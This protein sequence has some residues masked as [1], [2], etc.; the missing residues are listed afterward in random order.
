MKVNSGTV[1]IEKRNAKYS[2]LI[3]I[4]KKKKA[5]ELEKFV[6]R[7]AKTSGVRSNIKSAKIEKTSNGAFI[8]YAAIKGEWGAEYED[9][10]DVLTG[11]V[12][13]FFELKDREGL[14]GPV[15]FEEHGEPLSRYVFF[16]EN[17]LKFVS[18]DS[19]LYDTE[20]FNISGSDVEK[21]MIDYFKD[22]N[23]TYLKGGSGY[24]FLAEMV[25]VEDMKETL[26]SRIEVDDIQYSRETSTLT[27]RC[28]DYEDEEIS[29]I[30][31]D[32]AFDIQKKSTEGSESIYSMDI[33]DYF[34][35][36]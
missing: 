26:I 17:N 33:L 5:G 25:F 11:H 22:L 18:S 12:D 19:D 32:H 23:Y 28:P 15:V 27:F 21:V 36:M 29:L 3:G 1:F 35:D 20:P 2:E 7:I 13:Q 6:A 16:P 9:I 34:S 4:L 14:E 31:R 10:S 30:N 8:K 24:I